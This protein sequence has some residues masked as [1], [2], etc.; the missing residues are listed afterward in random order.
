MAA[1]NVLSDDLPLAMS[2]FEL[3]EM[4]SLPTTVVWVFRDQEDNW[5]VRE[6]GGRIESFATRDDAV[7]FARAAGHVGGAY[8]LFVEGADGRFA[9]ECVDP[10]CECGALRAGRAPGR[11]RI[12]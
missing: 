10:D 5:C 12:R 11:T 6:E 9:Q 2:R 3:D 4:T 1:L 7:A 8:R